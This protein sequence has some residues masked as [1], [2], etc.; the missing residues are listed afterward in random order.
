[1]AAVAASGAFVSGA[2]ALFP[3]SPRQKIFSLFLLYISVLASASTS[4]GVRALRQKQ[5][6][7]AH[8]ELWDL[9]LSA[10]LFAAGFAILAYGLYLG[11]PLLIGF[12]PVGILVGA[13]QLYYWLSTPTSRMHW[14]YEHM[15]GMLGA[16]IG[17]LTAFLVVNAPRL[18]LSNAGLFVWLTPALLGVPGIAIWRRY[19]RR[20]FSK[21]GNGR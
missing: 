19:Y 13:G 6:V 10:L 15:S 3:D 16:G 7:G 2:R 21:A 5:R 18:G 17:T 9:G 1:M 20:R 4:A 11:E 8:R 12:A 14:W